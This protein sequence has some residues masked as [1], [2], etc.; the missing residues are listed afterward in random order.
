MKTP[1]TFTLPEWRKRGKHRYAAWEMRTPV[2]TF[3]VRPIDL[4]FAW[5]F[6]VPGVASEMWCNSLDDGKERCEKIL[7]DQIR[8]VL[9]MVKGG[10]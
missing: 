7:E 3:T 9:M 6:S 4:P 1:Y 2:G 8:A 5:K 10:A